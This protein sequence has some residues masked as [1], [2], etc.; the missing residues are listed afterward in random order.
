M[1][2]G[3][4]GERSTEQDPHRA[5]GQKPGERGIGERGRRSVER[6]EPDHQILVEA[7]ADHREH[8]EEKEVEQDRRRQQ[9]L[10]ARRLFSA[11]LRWMCRMDDR[12]L[13]LHRQN[14]GRDDAE[15]RRAEKSAAPS[16][17]ALH[18]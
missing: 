3:A 2:C 5:H 11:W 8:H 12:R 18:E 13:S 16:H 14:E 17:R 15:Q 10:P 4:P 6:A 1:P 7:A 9:K